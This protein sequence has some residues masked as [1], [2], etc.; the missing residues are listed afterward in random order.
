[1]MDPVMEEETPKPSAMK[2][3][4]PMEPIARPAPDP[5]MEMKREKPAMAPPAPEPKSTKR[6][7][8]MTR[9]TP[10]RVREKPDAQSKVVAQIPRNTVVPV[11]QESKDWFQIEY[12]KG[13][14]G[15]ISKKYSKLAP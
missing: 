15:W 6:V 4:E 10:L 13:K 9:K 14:K 1:M 5:D 3:P 7:Q 2:R 8:I 11:F 12:Q